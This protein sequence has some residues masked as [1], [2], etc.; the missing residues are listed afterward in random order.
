MPVPFTPRLSFA[1]APVAFDFF[2]DRSPVR[3]ITGPVG[4]GKTTTA[5]GVIMACA[6]EQ[7]PNKDGYR[8]CKAGVVRNTMPQLKATTIR[9]WLSVFP[10]EACGPIRY[11]SPA[12]HH[13]V[14][15]PKNWRT[16]LPH[17]H[18]DQGSPG[19]DLRVE[20]FA[21]DTAKDVRNL[22]SWEGTILWFNEV[23]EIPKVIIDM[24]DLRV[25][26]Y[27][28]M[29][30]GGVR[31]AWY[32]WFGDTNTPDKDH[33]L[34]RAEAGVDEKGEY[35]GQPEGWRFFHQPPA[36]VQVEHQ[37]GAWHSV[38]GETIK[39]VVHDP[40]HVFTAAGR[41]W[42]INPN[43]ENLPNLEVHKH[44]D[45]TGDLLGRGSYYGRG[46]QA[47]AL[48]WIEVYFQGKYGFV[49]EGKPVVPAFDQKRMVSPDCPV[50]ADQPVLGGGDI[51]G[52]T[53]N[54]AAVFFQKGP[55]GIWLVQ[56]EVVA[57]DMGLQRFAEQMGISFREVYKPPMT[58]EAIY[59]D[60]AGRTRDG[61]FE[62]VAFDNLISNGWPAFPAPSQEIQVRVDAIT[63]PCTR[64]LGD[65]RAGILIHPRCVNLIAALSGKWQYKRL[66]V[67]GA[68]RFSEVPDKTHPW[69]D[70]AD[71]LGYG[72]SGA[73]E[74]RMT[75]RGG[76]R[77]RMEQGNAVVEFDV[78]GNG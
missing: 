74:T 33:W 75:A 71:G 58:C 66:A 1:H 39:L 72:L 19:L 78:F 63:T 48:D 24:A 7:T 41:Q 45:P 42:A 65:D 64:N 44:I 35:V 59:C 28:S 36:V 21:L 12:L 70:V 32:G 18:P 56:Q 27:P 40:K 30:Q 8:L 16:D 76:D 77:P 6:M 31:P 17:D 14:V 60:P 55:R 4:S 47:K 46:L 43:A 3:I 26:R 54:P 52:N 49:R 11:S 68:D 22:L 10:E 62:T 61:I 29:Q 34:Y 25:G 73:G 50:L 9:T 37:N 23:R 67:S 69:S 57:R 15:R 20:F 13:I 5:C 38:T 51:G 53:L 2:M